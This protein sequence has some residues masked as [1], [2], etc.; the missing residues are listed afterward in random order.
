MLIT[1]ECDYAIRVLRALAD[2]PVVCV[3]E[4]CEQE[5]ITVPFAYKIL[6]KLKNSNLVIAYRGV[7]GGYSFNE[8]A[9]DVTL[10]DV[11][12]AIDPNLFIIDCLNP[13]KPCKNHDGQGAICRVHLELARVQRSFMQMLSEKTLLQ[14]LREDPR[15]AVE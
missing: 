13:E 11:Y 6:N 12:Q 2:K 4:I 3:K 8:E 10:L 9:A 1:R 5:S 14:L 7:N 15:Q